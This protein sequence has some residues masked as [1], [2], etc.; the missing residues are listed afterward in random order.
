MSSTC[1]T[2]QCRGWSA[3][4]QQF[5]SSY[6]TWLLPNGRPETVS[7]ASYCSSMV[8]YRA[9]SWEESSRTRLGCGTVHFSCLKS[10]SLA[11]FVCRRIRKPRVGVC[12][13]NIYHIS[14]PTFPFG[15]YHSWDLLWWV[16]CALLLLLICYSELSLQAL[17]HCALSNQFC[18]SPVISQVLVSSMLIRDQDDKC[19]PDFSCGCTY[20]PYSLSSFDVSFVCPTLGYVF[21]HS[22]MHLFFWTVLP[23]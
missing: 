5:P 7:C 12:C 11:F 4:G 16:L 22:S 23:S 13:L 21:S 14:T 8:L 15:F 1:Q 10:T 9:R 20:T 6:S 18:S 17:V 19:P 3:Q 2:A